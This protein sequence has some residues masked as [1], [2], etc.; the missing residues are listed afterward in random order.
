MKMD[1]TQKRRMWK[2]VIAHFALTLFVFWEL[3]HHLAWS[4]P[5]EKEIWFNAW[6]LFW[7]KVFILLQPLLSFFVWVFN[8]V[9]VTDGDLSG[10][11][12]FLKGVAMFFSVPVWSLCF[13]WLFVKL[14]NWLNHFPVLG[15]KVF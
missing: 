7:L 6:G 1:A 10:L 14:D 9:G 8:L 3:L 12:E 2:V 15:K 5:P 11:I 4:G 13:G